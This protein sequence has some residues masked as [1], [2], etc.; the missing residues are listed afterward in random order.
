MEAQMF[1]FLNKNLA[2]EEKSPKKGRR[3]ANLQKQA[4]G[5]QL[6]FNKMQALKAKIA[7]GTSIGSD[8]NSQAMDSQ[9]S[10]TMT[11]KTEE[12][13]RTKVV[14]EFTELD[15]GVTANQALL[16]RAMT[17]QTSPLKLQQII[18]KEISELSQATPG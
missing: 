12:V 9:R 17:S 8:S 10:K 18:N 7:M 16:D 15:K 6:N 1:D 3:A 14:D 5:L 13:E 11:H 2:P 4:A